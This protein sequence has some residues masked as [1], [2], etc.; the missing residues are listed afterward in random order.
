MSSCR[1]WPAIWAGPEIQAGVAADRPAAAEPSGIRVR[2]VVRTNLTPPS[3]STSPAPIGAELPELLWPPARPPG[4]L[5]V[6][7]AARRC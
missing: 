5:R 1:R 3:W 7:T 2:C 4:R 6:G